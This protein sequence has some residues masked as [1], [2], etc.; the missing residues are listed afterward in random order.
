M[1]HIRH[2]D[3][4]GRVTLPYELRQKLGL[5]GGNNIVSLR[6]ENGEIVT[7]PEKICT[8]CNTGHWSETP[9]Q[10]MD[11]FNLLSP[12]QQDSVEAIIKAKCDAL[13]KILN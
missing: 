3:K 7:R 10:R 4:R 6:E 5:L 8:R 1:N 2:V 9:D 13:R 11:I 12:N